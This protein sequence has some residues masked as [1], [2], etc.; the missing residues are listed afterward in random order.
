[1]TRVRLCTIDPGLD[2]VALAFWDVRPHARGPK[3]W[4]VADD[5]TK[6]RDCFDGMRFVRTSPDD[7]LPVRL[8]HV[9]R[10]MAGTLTEEQPTR[11]WVERPGI[12]GTYRRHEGVHGARVG[13][14]A[15]GILGHHLALGVTI[16]AVYRWLVEATGSGGRLQLLKPPAGKKAD[17]QQNVRTKLAAS[18]HTGRKLGP[19]SLDAIGVGL[20]EPW[21]FPELHA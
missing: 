7:P 17:R 14:I 12:G 1:M 13:K 19:D 16:A 11:V 20:A 18:G 9:A 15:E 21:E 2:L 3:G 8:D 4:L 5:V 6:L 10:A